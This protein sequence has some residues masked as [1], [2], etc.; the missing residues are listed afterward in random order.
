MKTSSS[1]HVLEYGARRIVYHLH[2]S[3]GKR[4]RIVIS[5]DL[6]VD[7]YAPKKASPDKVSEAV[8]KK[9]AWIT[10]TLDRVEMYHPLPTPKKFI[11]GETFVYL[12][13]QY[14]LKVVSGPH[15]PAKLHG[16][17]LRV[18]SDNHGDVRRVRSA[19]DD[20]YRQRASET[21]GRYLGKCCAVTSRHGI[22]K[23]VLSMRIMRRRWG[24]CA[25]SGRITLNVKLVQVPVH[26]I[27][28][29]IMHELCH[30]VHHD[31]GPRFRGLLTRCLPDWRE[32]KK[33]LASVQIT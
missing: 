10:K 16:R 3:N 5:P 22:H 25:P 28:Y 9:A 33:A 11:S 6:T 4:L 8:Q 1:A 20:W 27:E 13:R 19:V 21:F 30:L 32:R 17:Y 26:C 18:Q 14:R 29:V 31:H 24:S 12:G 2:R 7:A 15:Q 23:P